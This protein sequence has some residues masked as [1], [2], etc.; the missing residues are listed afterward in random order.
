MF[1]PGPA[2]GQVIQGGELAGELVGLVESGV[3]RADQPEVLGDGGEHGQHRQGVRSADD[4]LVE[5]LPELLAQDQPF[6]EEEEV[7]LAQLGGPGRV[8][9]R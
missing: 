5:D 2:A 8:L 1:Q 9:E 3:D 4:V 7:E 6:G